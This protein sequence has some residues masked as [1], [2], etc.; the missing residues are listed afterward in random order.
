M[1]AKGAKIIGEHTDVDAKLINRLPF[2][3]G[4]VIEALV[5]LLHAGVHALIIEMHVL[6]YVPCILHCVFA[7]DHALELRG[8]RA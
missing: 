1:V 6:D 7:G 8:Y 4:D 2:L 3:E 5:E